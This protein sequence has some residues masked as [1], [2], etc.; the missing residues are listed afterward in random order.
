MAL[1]LADSSD[2]LVSLIPSNDDALAEASDYGEY[3]RTKDEAKLVFVDGKVPTRLVLNFN[4][5]GA[6]AAS[7]KNA[8][9]GGRDDDG[10]PKVT[11]GSWQFRIAKMALKEITNPPDLPENEQLKM[12]R[13]SNGKAHDDL[14][15]KLDRAGAVANIFAYYTTHIATTQKAASKNS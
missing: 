5:S 8:L 2:S 3:I 15:A 6:E 14:L 1:R 4:F 12:R 9:V 7:V 10:D 13:D 11:L